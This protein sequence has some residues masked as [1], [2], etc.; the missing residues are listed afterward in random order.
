MS[1]PVRR[2]GHPVSHA[3]PPFPQINAYDITL[4]KGS[5]R[6]GG[7]DVPVGEGRHTGQAYID[8]TEQWRRGLRR[9]S[10]SAWER[11]SCDAG[12]V[13]RGDGNWSHDQARVYPDGHRDG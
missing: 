9:P 6:H 4:I 10:S 3:A 11:N 12:S 1:A 7:A 13:L 8:K 2:A 5:Q